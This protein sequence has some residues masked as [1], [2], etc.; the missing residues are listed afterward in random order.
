MAGSSQVEEKK[1][2]I[3]FFIIPPKLLFPS[4]FLFSVKRCHSEIRTYTSYIIPKKKM[5]ILFIFY[6]SINFY[7]TI[8]LPFCD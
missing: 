2:A 4:F 3:I 8:T 5:E 1:M 6:F 7:I